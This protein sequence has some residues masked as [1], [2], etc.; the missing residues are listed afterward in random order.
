M[1]LHPKRYLS[2]GILFFPLTLCASNIDWCDFRLQQLTIFQPFGYNFT[3]EVSWNPALHLGSYVA[4][5]GN[6][7]GALL[8]G[9]PDKFVAIDYEA[10]ISYAFCKSFSVEAG[11]GAQTWLQENGGTAPTVSGAL[12]WMFFRKIPWMRAGITAG[13]TMFLPK[14]NLTHEATLG[15]MLSFGNKK[16]SL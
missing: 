12:S 10:R 6:I 5:R 4:I 8:K 1:T 13:Y 11:G 3:G 7:G 2:I 16:E 9:F 15:I 14:D